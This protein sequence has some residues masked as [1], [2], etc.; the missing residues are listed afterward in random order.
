MDILFYF[1][2]KIYLRSQKN[3][4]IFGTIRTIRIVENNTYK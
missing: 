2:N 3:V 1:L 4:N